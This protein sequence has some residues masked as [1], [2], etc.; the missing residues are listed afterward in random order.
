MEAGGN[1]VGPVLPHM[2]GWKMGRD[3]IFEVSHYFG[4]YVRKVGSSPGKPSVTNEVTE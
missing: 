4:I 2:A 3:G 1:I